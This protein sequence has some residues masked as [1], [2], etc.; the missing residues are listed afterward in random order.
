MGIK[1][2]STDIT[3]SSRI[4]MG[5]KGINLAAGDEVIAALPVRNTTDKLSLFS[6]YGLGKRV[7]L[8]DIPLQKRAGKGLICYKTGDSNGYV[9]AATLLADD[10]ILLIIGDKSSICIEAKEIPEGSR[11]MIGNILI[12]DNKILSVSKV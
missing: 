5:V 9:T 6:S 10:D 1:I 8:T 12:K 2:E 11:S 7:P 3:P 4:A